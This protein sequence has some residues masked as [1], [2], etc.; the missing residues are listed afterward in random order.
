M[1]SLRQIVYMSTARPKMTSDQLDALLAESRVRNAK[2]DITG[3]LLYGDGNI[4]QAIE[5]EPS[6]VEHLFESIQ[7]DPRHTDVTRIIDLTVDRRD[8]PDWR[9]AFAHQPHAE[10]IEACVNTLESRAA[11]RTDVSTRGIVGQVLARF[12]DVNDSTLGIRAP[13]G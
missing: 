13:A 4:V 1:S 8:F 7:N 9:M 11:I 12:I 3:I 6:A 10:A 5:G 2:T